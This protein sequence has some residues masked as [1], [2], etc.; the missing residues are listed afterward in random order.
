MLA[1]AATPI[2]DDDAVAAGVEVLVPPTGVGRVPA[3]HASVRFALSRGARLEQ[4]ERA[5]AVPLPMPADE[6]AERLAAGRAASGPDYDVV[7]WIG[8]T[9]PEWREQVVH[10]KTAMADAPS[11]GMEEPDDPWTVERLIDE[12][13]EQA[14]SGTEWIAAAARH[15]PSGELAGFTY[16]EAAADPSRPVSQEDTIV[17]RE[18][19]GHRL[20]MLV[21]V[22]NLDQLQRERPGHP[23][24]LTFNAEENRF[25]LDVNEAVG[26][27][28][29]AAEGAW[30]L[31]LN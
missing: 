6:L 21:K 1:W 22:A 3:D 2:V 25:M 16:F 29:V 26:F 23:A 15:L 31:D 7:T 10:L 8:A 27:V 30:R 17:L 13:A 9:P 19:R 28:P 5:S 14:E 20:G 24:V 4:V 11:A 12:E 18:H